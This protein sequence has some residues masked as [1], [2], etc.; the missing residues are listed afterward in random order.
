[1]S[2][3]P[4]FALALLLAGSA[5]GVAA[6][7]ASQQVEVTPLAAPDA[8]TTPGRSTGLPPELWSGA[9]ARTAR[10]VLPLLAAK[11]LSPAG[12]ALAR[13][14]LATGAPG[15]AGA[16][17]DPALAAARGNALMFQG[18]PKAA[19][20]VLAHVPGLDRSSEL[21]RAAA[22]SA[23]L[24]SDDPRACQ[25]SSGLSVGRDEVYWLKLRTFCQAIAGEKAQ[26]WLTFDLAQAQVKDPIFTRLMGAKLA[27]LGNPG[28]ASLRNGLDYALSR[29]L[30]LDLTTARPSP[31]VAAALATTDPG[32]PAFDPAAVPLD[33]AAFAAA[34]AKG[35]PPPDAEVMALITDTQAAEPKVRARAQAAALLAL[36]L[37]NRLT[38]DTRGLMAGL[39][40]PEGKAPVGRDLALE[41]AGRQKLM[42]EAALL[43]LWTCAE[44]GP[45][46]PA[47]GDRVRIVQALHA[48]GLDAD[49]RAFALE[50][51]VG[52]K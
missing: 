46:G 31:A 26:A 16:G 35:R 8:F 17:R 34:A 20:A 15:P 18:D 43:S 32:D 13:R 42:G 10:S 44:A 1:M 23:L 25:I 49:A 45:A 33:L 50:G 2:R 47:I 52:L 21:A 36:A 6:Q 51:L 7:A 38:P 5:H 48:V 11:S 12:S 27:G 40:L 22:E 14:I 39:S 28:S 37:E 4:G 41:S 30:G 9:S 3:L 19:A 24:S 29:D